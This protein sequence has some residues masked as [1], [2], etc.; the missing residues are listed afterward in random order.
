MMSSKYYWVL[1]ASSYL[2]HN[3]EMNGRHII[4]TQET[5]TYKTY[6][7]VS[8]SS[9]SNQ[10]SAWVYEDISVGLQHDG[11]EPNICS[12]KFYLAYAISSENVNSECLKVGM[13]LQ[14]SIGPIIT[15]WCTNTGLL[16]LFIL[17]A[18]PL[19]ALKFTVFGNK[20]IHFCTFPSPLLVPCWIQ[21]FITKIIF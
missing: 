18:W 17:P 9:L 20:M 5:M 21:W 1:S 10:K 14:F 16:H 11:H 4:K 13:H 15:C 12:D 19:K 8:P 6:K 3:N 7:T 2:Y